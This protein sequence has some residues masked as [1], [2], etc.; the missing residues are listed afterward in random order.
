TRVFALTYIQC[1]RSRLPIPWSM[2]SSECLAGRLLR[3]ETALS[4]QP[5]GAG[6]FDWG[7]TSTCCCSLPT[8]RRLCL[9]AVRLALESTISGRTAEFGMSCGK[10]SREK[11]DRHRPTRN[12]ALSRLALYFHSPR[13]RNTT[14]DRHAFHA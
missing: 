3:D 7:M 10:R 2:R 9:H 4:G 14:H 5:V 12:E 6:Y 11:S 8:I 13:T 1:L